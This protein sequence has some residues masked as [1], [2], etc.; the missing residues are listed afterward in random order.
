MIS[1]PIQKVIAIEEH[2]WI[3]QLRET[4]T[5]LDLETAPA[6]VSRLEDY[7][8]VRIREMDEAGIDIQVLSHAAP[9][10]QKLAVDESIRLSRKANDVLS[11]IISVNPARFAGFAALPTPDPN[12][13]ADELE[14]TVSKYGFKGAM[15]H[16]VSAG[17]RFLD[18]KQFWVIFERAEALD[19]PIYL[20]PA[21][22]PTAIVETYFKD[23]PE[24][25][26]AGWGF[27]MDTATQVYR[28]I[29]SGVFDRY[30][31]LKFIIGHLGESIPF[32]L[33]RSDRVLSRFGKV[34]HRFRDYFCNNF[35]ITTSSNFSQAG[36][37]CSVMEIGVDRILFAVD[38]PFMSNTDGRSFI[39]NALISSDDKQ[40]ILGLNAQRLL[41]M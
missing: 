26:R 15:L 40:K 18:E 13:A 22:P 38:W 23:Y 20:H 4:Y 37:I 11:D 9:A 35:Y 33:W 34:K 27:T 32:S 8:S 10:G 21:T 1:P 3:P 36:L 30:P 28:L 29:M 6:F 17:D 25:S 7:G 5:G 16:G 14:R 19:V 41:R 12:A 39:E 2:F 31:K 24:M